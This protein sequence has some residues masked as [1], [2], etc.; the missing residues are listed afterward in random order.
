MTPYFEFA[1]PTKL[2]SGA[3]AVDNLGYELEILGVHNPLLLSDAVLEKIGTLSLVIKALQG[4]KI[5]RIFT[6]VPRDSSV[7]TVN[8]AAAQYRAYG[9]DGIVAVGG[10]SV[11]DTAKGVR[12]LISQTCEDLLEL[13]G[14]ACLP[15]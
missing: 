15:A 7:E 9:C 4:R 13:M 6:D 10:G 1:N 5:G 2:C 8:E 11:L 3:G 14:C 12:L